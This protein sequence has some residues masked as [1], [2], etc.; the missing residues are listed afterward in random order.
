M[1]RPEEKSNTQNPK[2]GR[3]GDSNSNHGEY[4]GTRD[5][6]KSQVA[7]FSFVKD[8]NIARTLLENG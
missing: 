5:I 6:P 3:E 2:N 8:F 4:R 7:D 1:W